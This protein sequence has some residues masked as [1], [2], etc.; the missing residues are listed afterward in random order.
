MARSMAAGRETAASVARSGHDGSR[1]DLGPAV[2]LQTPSSRLPELQP[3]LS[4]LSS[5]AT[6]L[7][8]VVIVFPSYHPRRRALRRTPLPSPSL[9]TSPSPPSSSSMDP[10]CR[11]RRPRR[12]RRRRGL[13]RT[14]PAV[15]VAIDLAAA[16]ADTVGLAIQPGATRSIQINKGAQG[17][18]SGMVPKLA[19]S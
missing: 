2:D 3:S 11:C 4:S 5:Q 14:F 10:P 8:A 16:A 12:C 19:D 15:A 7:A 17:A 6:V 13:Q 18:E 1:V 9:S